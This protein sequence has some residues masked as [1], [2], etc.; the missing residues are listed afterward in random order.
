M[1]ETNKKKVNF[2]V[3]VKV[4]IEFNKIAKEKSINKSQFIENYLKQWTMEQK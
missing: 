4:L 2:N 3:N 1:E